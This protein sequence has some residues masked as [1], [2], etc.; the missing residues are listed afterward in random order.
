M[1][2]VDAPPLPPLGGLFLAVGGAIGVAVCAALVLAPRWIWPRR[3]GA[4]ESPVEAPDWRWPSVLGVSLSFVGLHLLTL[5]VRVADLPDPILYAMLAAAVA[6]IGL[7][8][9]ALGWLC[10]GHGKPPAALGLR[11]PW[12]PGHLVVAPIVGYGLAVS[13][14]LVAVGI[15][16]TIVGAPPEPQETLELFRRIRRPFLRAVVAVVVVVLAPAAEEV[17]FRGVLYRWMRARIGRV[18]AAA[19]SALLF[20]AVHL[21]VPQAALLFA[22]G[23]VLAFVVEETRSLWPAIALHAIFNGVALVLSWQMTSAAIP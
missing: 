6:E 10:A 12:W 5:V 1:G 8:A 14:V 15:Q 16:I 21:Q 3:S 2:A 22:L 13:A 11:M 17:L 9:L 18:L 19:I 4:A 23:L 7:I 20:S